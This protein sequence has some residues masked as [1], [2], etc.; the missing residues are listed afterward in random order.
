VANDIA[1]DT[2]QVATVA[3]LAQVGPAPGG[4]GRLVFVRDPD[5]GGLFSYFVA[6]SGETQ[7]TPNAGTVFAS[8]DVGIWRRIYD[9]YVNV[10]WFGAKGMY[11]PDN[12]AQFDDTAAIQAAIDFLA[13][14]WTGNP[15]WGRRGA[16]WLFR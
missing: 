13:T 15:G 7:P 3:D 2:R 4:A 12:P 10:K 8:A 1:L 14:P 11:D 9:G 5:R 6:G 16:R